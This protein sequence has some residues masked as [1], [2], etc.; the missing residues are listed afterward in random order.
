MTAPANGG[1]STPIDCE[2]FVVET[3]ITDGIGQVTY[4]H[5]S[6]YRRRSDAERIAAVVPKPRSFERKIERTVIRVRTCFPLADVL[7][8]NA[9]RWPAARDAAGEA[10]MERAA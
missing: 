3:A 5:G 8:G 7:A 1:A 6:I 2:G 4:Q 10:R 9:T